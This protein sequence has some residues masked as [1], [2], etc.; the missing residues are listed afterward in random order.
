MNAK[1]KHI[2]FRD[3]CLVFEFA[4]SK[5][6]QKG[7]EHVGPWHVHANQKKPWLCPVVALAHNLFCYLEILKG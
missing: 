6:N 3:D 7:G 2:A 4:K 5:E 1:I